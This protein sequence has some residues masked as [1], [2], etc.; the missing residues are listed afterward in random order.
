MTRNFFIIQW[1]VS[2]WLGVQ[3]LSAPPLP[4]RQ[5]DRQTVIA[6]KP[7]STGAFGGIRIL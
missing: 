6:T 1:V 7:R 4:Q 3:V 2:L 5:T